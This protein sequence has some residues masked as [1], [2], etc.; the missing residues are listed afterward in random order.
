[1]ARFVTQFIFQA[2]KCG[3]MQ[4]VASQTLQPLGN[5]AYFAPWKVPSQRGQK[6][7]SFASRARGQ[8]FV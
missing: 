2:P 3:K 1:M 4:G 8:I 6:G 5:Y 7:A